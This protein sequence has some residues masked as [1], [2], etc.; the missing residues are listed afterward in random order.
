M[1]NDYYPEDDV[2]ST[3]EVRAQQDLL[4]QQTYLVLLVSA[5]PYNVLSRVSRLPEEYIVVNMPDAVSRLHGSQSISFPAG[6][7]PYNIFQLRYMFCF[8]CRVAACLAGQCQPSIVGPTP[9]PD[10]NTS[11]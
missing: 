2:A 1:I 11:A 10:I 3:S 5:T 9:M 4:L 8:A 6:C 7:Q